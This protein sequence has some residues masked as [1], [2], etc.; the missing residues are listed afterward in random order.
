MQKIR[1]D[2]RARVGI[3]S[4][5][6]IMSHQKAWNKYEVALLVESYINVT[7]HG[8]N[9]E[10][11][12]SQLSKCLRHMAVLDGEVIDDVY[13]NLNGMHW[14]YA[15][16]QSV[17]RGKT[18]GNRNAPKMFY[19]MVSLYKSNKFAFDK[20]LDE[21]HQLLINGAKSKIVKVET[22][23][24]HCD[25]RESFA[26]WYE[27][28]KAGKQTTQDC[29]ECLVAVSD[30]CISHNI[31]KVD[32]WA[33][34]DYRI[35][36][37][38][39]VELS[40]ERLFKFKHRTL[41]KLFEKV[42]RYFSLFLKDYFSNGEMQRI[43]GESPQQA[44]E[45]PKNQMKALSRESKLEGKVVLPST[46]E[47]IE[48]DDSSFLKWLLTTKKLA[49]S[50]SRNYVTGLKALDELALSHGIITSSIFSV[51]GE[52]LI[53]VSKL[54]FADGEVVRYN[55]LQH[56]RFSAAL[57]A[58]IEYVTG[59]SVK[60]RSNADGI[61]H[62]L[63][64]VE[65][66]SKDLKQLLIRKFPYGIR[67]ESEIDINKLC[68]FAAVSEVKLPSDMNALKR[69]IASSGIAY[70][71]K[72]Y[73]ISEEVVVDIKKMVSSIINSG[74]SVIYYD[75]IFCKNVEWLDERHIS[76]TGLLKKILSYSLSGVYISKNFLCVSSE[77]TNELD[78]VEGELLNVWGS[79]ITHTYGELYECLP[80][81]PQ[82]K[83]RLYLSLSKH[84]V[85]NK[86]EEFAIIDRFIIT[87]DEKRAIYNFV[88]DVCETEGFTSLYNI[89][90]FNIAETNFELSQ[91]A[92]F[93]AIYTIVLS[94]DFSL[95]G[96]ILS[97]HNTGTNLL[98]LTKAYCSR[99]EQ[100]SLEEIE[101]YIRDINGKPSRHI[102]LEAA[103]DEMV[104]ISES[105]FV[106]DG[107]VNFNVNKVDDILKGIIRED[108][109]AI[110]SVVT[111][112]W[113]PDCN[114]A[115][116]H[117]LLESYCYKYSK[118]FKLVVINFNDKNAG[119]IAKK[120]CKKDYCEMLAIVLAHAPI[121]LTKE[122]A[123]RYLFN[124]CYIAK[125]K[126]F[127]LDAAVE[128]AKKFREVQ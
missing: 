96:K 54:I 24:N 28:T 86:S 59:A 3:K 8:H 97:K 47:K 53:A 119:I 75:E 58:Y 67:L 37:K 100:C 76:S 99:Q 92:I 4:N 51:C 101:S 60:I 121:M 55:S 87:E 81:I 9:L 110:K 38:I 21:A 31:S 98:E 52:D 7:E 104:R 33:I 93:N 82:E 80:Y 15:L 42:G 35:F 23:V 17:F 30:Y 44:K 109:I 14:Q 34:S 69:Q 2:N 102:A 49:P 20:V 103:Y 83:I 26:D 90:L 62:D 85:W 22:K 48:G 18:Y 112:A 16:L 74:Y 105:Q 6:V 118:E 89:P 29:L 128:K 73:Y 36:N 111:F 127:L 116:N 79:S 71:G 40:G 32:L 117:Y 124:N 122:G 94:T 107:V 13:R 45:V 77:R 50:S 88:N 123:G 126:L 65:S 115:W 10:V 5:E 63:E 56:N 43:Q 78:A 95:N 125:R 39:R 61:K 68:A 64:N 41:F 57:N 113:F 19:E 12:L 72:I 27:K 66:C 1:R 46:C 114:F 84:F 25:W 70:D 108:F 11:E 91:S 120:S 106:T